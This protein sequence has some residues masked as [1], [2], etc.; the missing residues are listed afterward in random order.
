ME[1]LGIA[2]GIAIGIA[3]LHR[4]VKSR[5]TRT[6]AHAAW[7]R[8]PRAHTRCRTR[9]PPHSAL[10]SPSSR[11]TTKSSGHRSGHHQSLQHTDILALHV[12]LYDLL[13]G[14][15]L[16]DP[17]PELAADVVAAEGGEGDA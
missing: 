4:H 3:T 14:D 13:G 6:A 12:G 17:F 5:S 2:I 8:P 9:S 16:A 11:P 15:E 7:F 10:R 1:K